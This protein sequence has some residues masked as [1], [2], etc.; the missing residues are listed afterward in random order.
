MTVNIVYMTASSAEEA[1]TIGQRLVEERLA[2]CVNILG[3]MT[4]I[5]RWQGEVTS[6]DE[7][8][9]IAKTRA[10]LIA[11]LVSRVQELHSYDCPCVVALPIESGS[12]EFLNWIESETL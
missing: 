6:D 12:L 10:D 1:A 7:V 3:K 2:A 9:F 5:Y 11:P 4:S 8:A